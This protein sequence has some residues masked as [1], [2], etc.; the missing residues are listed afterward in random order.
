M[1][2]FEFNH[3]DNVSK[4]VVLEEQGQR[5]EFTLRNKKL[6]TPWNEGFFKFSIPEGIEIDDQR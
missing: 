4:F 1:F 5:S 6:S 2:I 3:A